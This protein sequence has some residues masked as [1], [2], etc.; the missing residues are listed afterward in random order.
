MNPFIDD[1][2]DELEEPE[3]LRSLH[4]ADWTLSEEEWLPSTHPLR[5]GSIRDALMTGSWRLN[6]SADLTKLK[7]YVS[8][9][10]TES[11]NVDPVALD[12]AWLRPP[13]SLSDEFQNA[14]Y[15]ARRIPEVEL[16]PEV[17][18]GISYQHATIDRA[19]AL[20]R[21]IGEVFW[22]Q[23]GRHLASP[24]ID[25]ATKGSIDLFWENAEVSLLVNV[26]AVLD[27]PATFF[28]KRREGSTISGLF[29]PSD[30]DVRHLVNWLVIG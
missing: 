25:P 7:E 18:E 4:G 21:S 9:F 14:L 11:V 10:L 17:T 16:D 27:K 24:S 12:L 30:T 1:T 23:F 26:S 5:L 22:N 20:A 6:E 29:V 8:V 19:V 15:A 3:P 2:L 13:A 28:G